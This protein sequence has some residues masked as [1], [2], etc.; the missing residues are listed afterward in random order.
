MLT[1]SS[2]LLT[3]TNNESSSLIAMGLEELAFL[4]ITPLVG[5]AASVFAFV[6]GVAS[7]AGVSPPTGVSPTGAGAG[8]PPQACSRT[9]MITMLIK[10]NRFIV[11]SF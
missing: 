6:A 7:P 4:E 9:R 2:R 11:L 3:T 1:L 5:G 8:A 10:R